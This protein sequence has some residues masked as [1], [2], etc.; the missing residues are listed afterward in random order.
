MAA[1]QILDERVPGGDDPRGPAAFQAAHRPQPGLQPPVITPT[2]SCSRSPTSRRSTPGIPAPSR[3]PADQRTRYRPGELALI[4]G[5]LARVAL[6]REDVR[7]LMTIPGVDATVALSIVAAVG[8]FTRF[9]TPERL[10]RYF[11]LSPR[12]RQSGGQPA[13]HGR[14]TKAGAGHARGMLAGAAWA[15]S[16][17][18][19]PLRASCQRVR[20]RCGMR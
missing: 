16:K 6:G 18:P 3:P 5:D 20:S 13:S 4:D 11:G 10:V 9:R 1:A 19:G 2:A 15:A 12:E 17:A 14:I 8:D 7:R